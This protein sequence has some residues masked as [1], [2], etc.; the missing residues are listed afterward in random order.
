MQFLQVY[1]NWFRRNS[2]LKYVSRPEIDKKSIK[3]LFW[4]SWSSKIIEFCANRKSVYDFLL[5]I[6]SNLSPISHRYWDTAIYWLKITLFSYPLLFS[7]LF[8]RDPFEFIEK[9]YGS[10]N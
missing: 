3:L 7:T 8:R 5:A 10:W 6:N 2:H 1:L 9:L 4:R